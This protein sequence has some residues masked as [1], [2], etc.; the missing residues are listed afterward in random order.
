MQSWIAGLELGYQ[1]YNVFLHGLSIFFWVCMFL[2]GFQ[3]LGAASD[4][5]GAHS[6]EPPCPE[7]ARTTVR[8]TLRTP[9]AVY[10]CCEACD[11]LWVV[12]KPGAAVMPEQKLGPP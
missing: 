3:F 2:G 5:P 11:H 6:P 7:C 1:E 12:Q 8:A 9:D 10:Y 4:S